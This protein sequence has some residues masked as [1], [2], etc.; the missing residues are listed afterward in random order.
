MVDYKV[1][2]VMIVDIFMTITNSKKN[3]EIICNFK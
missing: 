2:N 3:S 1:K